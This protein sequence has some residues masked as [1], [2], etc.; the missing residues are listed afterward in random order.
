M[1][2]HKAITIA[3]AQRIKVPKSGQVDHFDSSFPGLALRVAAGGRKSW[4]YFYRHAGKLR[5]M[6]FD[7]FPAMSVSAAHDKWRE[8]RD[9]VQS[10]RDPACAAVAGRTDFAGVA[11]EWLRRDQEG[12]R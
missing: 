6:T 8:A 10:G 11:E 5:R 7:V 12:H 1:P 4:T 2:K 3:S 9:L